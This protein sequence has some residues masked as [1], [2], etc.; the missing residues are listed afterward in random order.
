[1]IRRPPRSTLFP[2]TTLFRSR[3]SYAQ[4]AGNQLFNP[5]RGGGN[6]VKKLLALVV[7][8]AFAAGSAGVV[9]AQAPTPAP[10]GEKAGMKK[11]PGQNAN[12]TGKAASAE[13]NA[14]AG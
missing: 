10:A 1:M 12:G 9:V 8:L 6:V 7:A 3:S 14:G 13:S 2:Y 4:E 5:L 11:M